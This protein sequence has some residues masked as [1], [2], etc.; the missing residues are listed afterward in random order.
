MLITNY[1]VRQ[2]TAVFVFLVVMVIAGAIGYVRLPREGTPDLTIPFVFVTAAYQGVAPVEMEN[3]VTI[4]LERQFRGLENVKTVRSTSS[5]GVSR[6]TIEFTDQEDIESAL[7]KVKDRMDLA[8]PDLPSDL[9]EPLA[10]SINFSTDFPILMMSVAGETDLQRLKFIA[11]D[12]SDRIEE[13]SGI[14]EVELIGLREREIRVEVD[15]VRASLYGLSLQE[16]SH[17]IRQENRTIS[18]GNLE[19]ESATIQIRLPGEF[20]YPYELETLIVAQ[21]ADGPVYLADLAAVTD[22]FKDL[23]SISRVDGKPAISMQIKK[24]SGANTVQIVDQINALLADYDFPPGIGTV[25]IMDQ[26]HYIRMMIS[27]LENNI[28]T[29]FI[30]VIAVLFLFMGLRNSVLVALAIPFSMLLSFMVLRIMGATLNMIVL[31]SLVIAVGMLVDNAIVI[32]ENIFRIH[33]EGTPRSEAARLGA[34]QVA[35]PIITSTL[36]TLAAFSPLLF[37]PGLLGEFMGFMPRTLIIVLTCSLFVALVINPAICSVLI[38]P[39]A[40]QKLDR[41]HF[42]HAFADRYEDFLRAALGNR[43]LI[44]FFGFLLFYFS[45]LLFGRYGGDQELFPD[46][47][48]ASATVTVRFPEGVPIEKTDDVLRKIEEAVQPYPDVKY[49]LST[50][51]MIGGA[52]F[53]EDFG[54]HVGAVHIEFTDIAD[55]SRDSFELLDE[56]RQRIGLIPGAVVVIDRERAGPPVGDPIS[57]E[58]SG[59][60]IQEIARISDTIM[61]RIRGTPGLVD[62]RADVELARPEIIFLVDRQRAAFYGPDTDQIGNFLRTSIFGSEASKY[63]AGEDQFDITIRLPLSQRDSTDLLESILVPTLD[64]RSVPLSSLGTLEY[65]GGRGSIKRK[66]HSRVITITGD[67]TDGRTPAA[68]LAEIQPLISEIP[69]PSGYRV[70]FAGDHQEMEEARAFLLGAFLI[71]LGLIAVI[72]VIQFNSVVFPFIIMFSVL[73]SMIGVLLGLIITR[74]NFVV[75]MTGVGII[76]LAGVVVNNSIVLVDCILQ[77]HREGM[78]FN[79]AIIAACKQRL[80]PVLLTAITTILALLPMA[81]GFSFDFHGWPPTI[82]TDAETSAFWA[83]M[84]VAVIFGLGVASLLTLVQVPVMCSVAE[85]LA[86]RL[87]RINPAHLPGNGTE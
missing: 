59:T 74:M 36:T 10:Q 71:A 47:E 33:S 23:D 1:A 25:A 42:F 43:F 57:I 5:E 6:I 15:L 45:I 2:R 60:E 34:S 31:F 8:W 80:R 30:L 54:S 69:L 76:S 13:I 87:R 27:E 66:D 50:A 22:T 65:V 62:L 64:G 63:R 18:A 67:T 16:I 14:R 73:M 37:W 46:I 32:V 7:Q 58:V 49:A 86:T 26:A 85:S 56:I 77:H 12:L 44:L 19:M 68:V 53:D 75:I 51:G 11:E 3:L 55:R 20:V 83:P 84:A 78:P 72:L 24:R 35:W 52:G 81:I 79:D 40:R 4:P 28:I 82:M 61:R 21:R 29:G 39:E 17:R 70:T 38:R 48:P 41:S 9:D